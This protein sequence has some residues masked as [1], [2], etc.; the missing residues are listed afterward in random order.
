MTGDRPD[1]LRQ[2]D[3]DP[4]T[5]R[6]IYDEWADGYD[7]DLAMWGYDVPRVVAGRLAAAQPDAAPVLDVGCGTGLAGR[8]L[9]AAGFDSLVGIDLSA[10]SLEL[11]Q[12]G[13][14]YRTLHQVDVQSLPTPFD[15][16]TFAA[17]VCVGVMTYLPDTAA[18]VAEFCR[19]VRSGGVILFTQRE[20]LWDERDCDDVLRRF[21]AQGRCRIDDISPPLPY[22]PGND[23]LADIGAIVV[24]LRSGR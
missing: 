12:E 6:P 4:T 17:S 19:L 13:G 23:G 24:Q 14:A 2:A 9:K 11:A 8:E 1:W 5:V 21:A 20:D 10:R 18:T 3:S 7:R 15:D 16:D 22:L